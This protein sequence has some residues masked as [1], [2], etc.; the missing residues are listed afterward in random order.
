MTGIAHFGSKQSNETIRGCGQPSLV[1]DFTLSIFSLESE[2]AVHEIRH[3]EVHGARHESAYVDGCLLP[4]ENS[5]P[6]GN[7]YISVCPNTPKNMTWIRT[8]YLIKDGG[9]RMGLQKLDR[10]SRTNVK[11]IP[12]Y[13]SAGRKLLDEHLVTQA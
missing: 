5:V 13:G 2:F 8:G 6:I 3:R 7:E 9:V 10:G 12:S 1:S 4:E 11:I